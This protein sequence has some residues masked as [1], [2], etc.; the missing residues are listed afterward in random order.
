[1]G[2]GAECAVPPEAVA[3]AGDS[4]ESMTTVAPGAAVPV[5]VTVGVVTV[6]PLAGV[7]TVDVFAVTLEPA[8]G[9]Q[10]P[11]GEMYL[12]SQKG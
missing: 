11:T 12:A 8:A 1:V 7:A 6:A 4:V 5:T 2:T 9:V 10:S 3:P